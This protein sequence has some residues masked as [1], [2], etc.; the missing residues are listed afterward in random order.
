MSTRDEIR[1]SA[2]LFSWV[3]VDQ[4]QYAIYTRGDQSAHVRYRKDGSVGEAKLY[5]FFKADDLHLL[6]TAQG[7]HKRSRILHWLAA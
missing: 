1:E 4:H 3:V 5:R 2:E 7:K 6:E